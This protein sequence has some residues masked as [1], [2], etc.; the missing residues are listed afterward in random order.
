M[1][2]DDPPPTPALLTGPETHEPNLPH[3]QECRGIVDIP[4]DHPMALPEN[5]N[6]PTVTSGRRAKQQD[7]QPIGETKYSTADSSPCHAAEVS[8]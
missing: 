1:T 5:E 6:A 3:A 8:A 2:R 7:K 4:E